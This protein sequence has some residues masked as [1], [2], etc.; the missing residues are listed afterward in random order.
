MHAALIIASGDGGGG[1]I[2]ALISNKCG[3]DAD[4]EDFQ[5]IASR[6]LIPHTHTNGTSD[7]TEPL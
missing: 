4:F 2:Y 5:P 1:A 7:K 3:Q 6:L